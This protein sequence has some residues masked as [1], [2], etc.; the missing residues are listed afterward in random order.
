MPLT[1]TDI[2]AERVDPD[3]RRLIG[4]GKGL[5]LRIMA[6]G[7]RTW[8]W[9]VKKNGDINYFT[10]GVWPTMSVKEARLALAKRRVTAPNALL[11]RDVLDEW[12][13]DVIEP[14]YRVT[15]N[16]RVY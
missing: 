11:V 10:L 6:S 15:K 5:Y 2:R 16:T 12:F 1:E 14:R 4:D 7:R 3:R 13:K 8:I 9:R